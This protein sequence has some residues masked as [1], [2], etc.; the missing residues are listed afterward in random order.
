MP[1]GGRIFPEDLLFMAETKIL[2]DLN[3]VCAYLGMAVPEDW[4]TVAEVYPVRV[5][6]SYLDLVDRSD[7]FG[8]P[9]GRQCLPHPDELLDYDA[10]Y[11]PLAET[12]QT[13]AP[14][15]I[16]RYHDRVVML[17]T[18]RCPSLCRF[19]FRKRLW[20]TGASLPDITDADLAAVTDWLTGH[21]DVREVLVSGGDPLMLSNARLAEIFA[22]LQAV[23]SLEIVRLGS[24]IPVTWP[25]RVDAG[26]IDLLASVPG[27]WLATHFNHPRE[28]SPAA[29]DV[30]TRL[31]RAGV[32]IVN[33]T[34]LLK[35]VND[36]PAVLEDLFRQLIRIRVKPHYLFHVDPVKGVRH[37]ATGIERGREVLRYFRPRLTSL[38]VPTFAIDLP[39]GGG[40]VHLQA[41]YAVANGFKTIDGN[42]VAYP[43]QL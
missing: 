32:P 18:S 20:K 37:F 35:G 36:D 5:S 19:C 40:K 21:P 29:V 1:S 27:L 34:V 13:V 30:C 12:V 17:T 7:P 6:T 22:R 41:E 39:E 4:R 38:A 33:Q 16:R 14:R 9:I 25:E 15:L 8:D 23:P 43:Q 31:V 42:V 26:L 11:D 2:S 24:R 28:L 10:S 3:A